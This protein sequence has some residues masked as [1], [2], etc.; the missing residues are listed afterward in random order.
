MPKARPTGVP[1]RSAGHGEEN[2]GKAGSREPGLAQGQPLSAEHRAGQQ[3]QRRVQ[4]EEQDRQT[5]GQVVQGGKK[6]EGLA[7]VAQGTK[8]D[9]AG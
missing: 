4:V 9:Q 2:A 8:Q 1:V 5:D 6:A 7:G 3:H